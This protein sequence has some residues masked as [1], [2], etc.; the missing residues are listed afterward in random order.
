MAPDRWQSSMS[1]TDW[2]KP[3]IAVGLRANEQSDS[4]AYKMGESLARRVPEPATA[5]ET[6]RNETGSRAFAEP[7]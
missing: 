3:A 6:A 7:A 5:G 1:T 4:E 2:T